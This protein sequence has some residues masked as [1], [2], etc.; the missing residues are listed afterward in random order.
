[1]GGAIPIHRG[2]MPTKT[3]LQQKDMHSELEAWQPHT[4]EGRCF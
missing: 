2:S 4:S 3:V 1:M